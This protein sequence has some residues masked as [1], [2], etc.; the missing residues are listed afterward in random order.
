[1]YEITFAG[2]A[3]RGGKACYAGGLT[4]DGLRTLFAVAVENDGSLGLVSEASGALNSSSPHSGAVSSLAAG[5]AIDS[6]RNAPV[7]P[8][9]IWKLFD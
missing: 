4:F 5:P 6:S 2:P 9:Y 1:M 8:L 3:T 7:L